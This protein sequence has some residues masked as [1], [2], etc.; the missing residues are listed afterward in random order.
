VGAVVRAGTK[1][2]PDAVAQVV[3]ELKDRGWRQT[4]QSSIDVND[5]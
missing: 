4:R 3:A 1:P 5:A 2:D